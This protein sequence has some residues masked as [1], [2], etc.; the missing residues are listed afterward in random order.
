MKQRAAL[1]RTLALK[2]DI[3]LL[4]EPLSALDSQSRLTIGNDIFNI[5]KEEGKTAIMVTHDLGEA[6]SNSDRIIVLTKRPGKIKNI[7]NIDFDGVN[8]PTERRKLSSFIT[9]QD[10]IWRDLDN[11]SQ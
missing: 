2:P 11:E 10:I 1:I 3:L 9:M 8:V 7:Y 6:L 5:I 4:D